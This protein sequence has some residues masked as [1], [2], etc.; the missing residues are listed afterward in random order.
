MTAKTLSKLPAVCLL[1]MV[2]CLLWGSAFPAI[3]IGYR[4]FDIASDDTAGQ[5][6]FAGLRFTF[7]GFLVILIGSL[8]G[9]KLLLPSK[10]SMGKIVWLSIFQTILQYLFFYIGLAN[11]AGVKGSIINGSNVFLS[12]LAAS[13]IFRQEKL[14]IQKI[15]GCLIGFAG[16][17]VINLAGGSFDMKMKLTGEGFI[18]LSAVSYA[19][20]SALIKKFSKDENPVMLSGY[21][22]MLGGLV[23]ILCGLAGGGRITVF[24]A[25]SAG[26][27]TY[28]AF[29][30]AIAYSLW[31]ILLKY[32]PVSRV[33]VFGFMNPVFGVLLSALFL[34]EK[35]QAFG[36]NGLI[37]LLLVCSGIFIVN[38]SPGKKQLKKAA[39]E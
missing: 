19:V 23:M 39:K 36:L 27:L 26:I 7:A 16:V 10:S 15:A 33:A 11:T 24:T 2:C 28:L 34:N 12:I 4:L 22:F 14:T 5:I 1:A 38:A 32:N 9:R 8:L 31:G 13:L 25:G 17:V 35:D 20:S 6:L 21:Q 18:L 37:A 3:K 30:S 29:L